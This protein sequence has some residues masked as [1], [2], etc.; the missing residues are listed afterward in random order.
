MLI[1]RNL[2]GFPGGTDTLGEEGENA[3]TVWDTVLAA[4][5]Q[6]PPVNQCLQD[7]AKSEN[8]AV[9]VVLKKFRNYRVLIL[10]SFKNCFRMLKS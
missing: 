1:F 3:N 5:G 4:H 9:I 6:Y 2:S 10:K 7:D 8:E